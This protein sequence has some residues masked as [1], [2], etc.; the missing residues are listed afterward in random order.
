MRGLYENKDVQYGV[1]KFMM[2]WNE[3]WD[4]IMVDALFDPLPNASLAA[5]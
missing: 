1:D 4:A 2:S 3:Y 5:P